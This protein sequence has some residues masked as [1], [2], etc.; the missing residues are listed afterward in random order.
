MTREDKFRNLENWVDSLGI[1]VK[2]IMPQVRDILEDKQDVS[3]VA[4]SK[5]SAAGTAFEQIEKVLDEVNMA[6][7]MAREAIYQKE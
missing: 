1:A 3:D 7:A 6:A 4:P 5:E 2:G